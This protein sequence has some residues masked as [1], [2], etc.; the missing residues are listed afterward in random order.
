[1][2]EEFWIRQHEQAQE[3]L[4]QRERALEQILA[5]ASAFTEYSPYTNETFV[6]I[7]ELATISEEEKV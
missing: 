7:C 1:M 5:E 6:R 4:V 3:R 2:S